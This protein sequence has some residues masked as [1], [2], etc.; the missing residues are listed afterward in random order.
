MFVRV[1]VITGL[2][3]RELVVLYLNLVNSAGAAGGNIFAA[4]RTGV[5]D[6]R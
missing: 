4:L 3:L 1:Y 5:T 2:T 6:S